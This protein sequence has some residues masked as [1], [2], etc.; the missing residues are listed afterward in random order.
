MMRDYGFNF[1]HYDKYCSNILS[2]GFNADTS[3]QIRYELLTAFEVFEHL[4]NPHKEIEK[5]LGLSQNILFTTELIPPS[6]PKPE[7]WWYYGLE[8]GQHISFYARR[9]L[10]FIA[11]KHNLHFYSANALHLLSKKKINKHLFALLAKS[12]FANIIGPFIVQKS[13]VKGDFDKLR[14]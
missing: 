3:L 12:K 13:L 6:N 5:M 2:Q 9:T 14:Q 10:E 7:D 8:H 4:V 11:R 1:Y